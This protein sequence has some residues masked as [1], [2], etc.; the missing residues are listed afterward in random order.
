MQ[1]QG[2]DS[3]KILSHILPRDSVTPGS[4]SD[5]YTV[6]IFQRHGKAINLWLYRITLFPAESRVHAL[7][8][9]K[10]LIIGKNVRQALQRHLVM[11]R[12]KF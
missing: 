8:E 11:H 1:G 9:G 12:L 6:F 5:K 2:A 10:K 4:A 3:A 7:T